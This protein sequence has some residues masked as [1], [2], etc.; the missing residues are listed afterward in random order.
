MTLQARMV[1]IAGPEGVGQDAAELDDLA[2]DI[3]GRSPF[4]PS[5]V[6]RPRTVE[7]LR[8]TIAAATAAGRAVVPRG[9]GMSYTGGYEAGVAGAVLL[10]LRRL[11]RVV[12]IAARDRY[13]VVEAGCT[14]ATLHDALAAQG[15]RTP[16]FGPL[17]G[18]VATVGGALSQHAAFFGSASAGASPDSVLGLEIVTTDG[19]LLRTG[20]WAA[21]GRAPFLRAFG[22]DLT[23]LFL[24]DC[25]ALGV[26]AR[27]SLRLLPMPASAYAS[28]AFAAAPDMVAAQ[29]ALAGIDGLAE[30]FGFDP[31][32]NENLKRTGFSLADK[33]STFADV[34]RAG[35]RLRG[36]GAAIGL[37]LRRTSFLADVRWSL[38]L[39]A[40]GPDDEAAAATLARA[41]TIVLGREGREIADSVPRATRARPFR[42][43]KAL[44][45][46]E[47]EAWLPVHGIVP[48]SRAAEAVGAVESVLAECEA[49]RT[50]HDIRVSLLTTL[51]GTAFLVE[52]QL[53]WPD[54]LGPFQRRHVTEAQ[55][56]AYG[57]RPARPEARALAHR[58]RRSLAEALDR[59][60]A[61]HFQIGT[62]YPYHSL[63]DPTARAALDGVK[64]LLDPRGLM[65]PG[66]LGLAS[67]L[68]I[69]DAGEP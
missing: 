25:G 52:P 43:I 27:A 36:L 2:H 61:T 39:V 33:A 24:G 47:G 21:A 63:L 35:G 8:A 41:R 42:P 53:F 30:C 22:P 28:F 51:V 57:D 7:E 62:F 48:L 3:A 58:L 19:A 44:L 31:V 32:A 69:T 9:G 11:D 59:L 64:A 60:G 66:A 45:G 50:A 56:R 1:E 29:V 68:P 34:A 16:F 18:F 14:W 15:L 10:D 26:K 37:G 46:P 40:D 38:H 54:A 67:P 17:S 12:E 65:N 49:E 6:V 5:L 4:P 23:S 13:V 55:R 20:A